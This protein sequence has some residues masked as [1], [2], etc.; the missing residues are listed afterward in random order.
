MYNDV[1]IHVCTGHSGHEYMFLRGNYV[2]CHEYDKK[3][4]LEGMGFVFVYCALFCM[5]LSW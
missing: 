4:F 3:S 1:C 5:F 2:I